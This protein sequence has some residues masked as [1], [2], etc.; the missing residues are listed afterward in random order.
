MLLQGLQR[1]LKVSRVVLLLGS[2]VVGLDGNKEILGRSRIVVLQNFVEK[3]VP[4]LGR[5]LA[6]VGLEEK[7]LEVESELRDLGF[8]VHGLAKDGLAV[9]VEESVLGEDGG[10]VGGIAEGDGEGRAGLDVV[11]GN[12]VAVSLAVEG[13]FHVGVGAVIEL[14]SGRGRKNKVNKFEIS[15]SFVKS[16]SVFLKLVSV[17]LKSVSLISSHLTPFNPIHISNLI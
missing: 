16:V 6:R 4:Y 17:F 15:F 14:D 10:G 8:E 3:Y 11:G 9:V 7:V 1:V 13:E 12:D 5:Y 2:L